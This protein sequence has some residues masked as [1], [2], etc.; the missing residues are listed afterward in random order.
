MVR[1]TQEELNRLGACVVHDLQDYGEDDHLALE[2]ECAAR[3]IAK[4]ARIFG[5]DARQALS[6]EDCTE[7]WPDD[8]H[9][10][11]VD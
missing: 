7:R 9:D 6:A 10:G 11:R 8:L 3:S 4:L 2:Y 5:L 1:V